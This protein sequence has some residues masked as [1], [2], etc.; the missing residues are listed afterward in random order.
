MSQVEEHLA[1]GVA[2]ERITQEEAD[3][4]LAQAEEHITELVNSD[5]PEPGD[6]PFGRGGRGPGADEDSADI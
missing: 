1:E 2:A 3:E 4:K 6:R 5:I